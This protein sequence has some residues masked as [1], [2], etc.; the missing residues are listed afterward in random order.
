VRTVRRLADSGALK[1]IRFSPQGWLRFR[2][3]EVEQF[4]ERAERTAA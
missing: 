3:E 1:P 2:P 4:L